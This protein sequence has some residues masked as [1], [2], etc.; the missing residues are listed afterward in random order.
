METT[1]SRSCRRGSDR[2]EDESAIT[3]LVMSYGPAADAGLTAFAGQLWLE[4]GVYDW[5]AEGVPHQGSAG[6]DAMLQGDGHQGLIGAGSRTSR[7]PA[8]RPRRRSCHRV[9][10]LA[11]HATRGG[12]A[13]PVARERG[14]VGPRAGRCAMADP[15][16][17][18]PSARRD[19]CRPRAVRRHTARALRGGIAMTGGRLE[20]KVAIITGASTGLGP[21]MAKMFVRRRR[22][23]AARR[24]AARSS[25]RRR[26]RPR[27]G[28]RSRCAPT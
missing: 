6:V 2:L 24:R 25:S 3:K 27:A 7:A 1:H 17:D 23:R 13:L 12:P 14:P 28:A 21:V 22:T 4:D 20:G 11:D 5:D 9:E 15:A 19:R 26:P 16:P 10:L 18:Q 8:D